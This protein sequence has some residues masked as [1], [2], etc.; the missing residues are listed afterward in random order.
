MRESLVVAFALLALSASADRPRLVCR[1]DHTN[2]LYRCGETARFSAFLA[3]DGGVPLTNGHVKVSLDNCDETRPLFSMQADLSVTNAFE[4]AGTLE[5]PGFLRMTVDGLEGGRQVF[6]VGFEPERIRVAAR[7]P[8]DFDAYWDDAVKKLDREVPIDV[9]QELV[10]AKCNARRDYYNVDFATFGRR[11]YGW[12]S[13][14]RGGGKRPLRVEVSCAGT[15]LRGTGGEGGDAVCLTFGVHDFRS[16]EDDAEQ[17]RLYDDQDRRWGG[18]YGVPRYCQAGIGVSREAYFYYSVILGISRA[19]DWAVAQPYVDASR[20]R[21]SGISQGGGF[22]LYLCGLNRH[23]SSGV[24]FV[25]ALTDILG[26]QA[27]RKSGWPTLIEV[28]PQGARETA[29][30]WAPY[31]ECAHFARRITC[32]TRTFIGFADTTCPPSAVYAAY[33]AI[34]VRTDKAIVHGIGRGHLGGKEWF[35]RLGAWQRAVDRK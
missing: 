21:Y 8:D 12:L 20:V 32:P 24:F 11:V 14:P 28:Q 25:P 13:I 34:P 18:R 7:L 22:G 9:R 5:T 27:G 31:F 1:A 10:P 6:A 4:L 16:V 3:G 17:K 19:V 33:N 26:Y 15:G 29:E 2:A 35:G 30:R 23:F